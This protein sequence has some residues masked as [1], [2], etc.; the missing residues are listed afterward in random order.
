MNASKP[1]LVRGVPCKFAGRP[2]ARG[3]PA[4]SASWR[5]PV[6]R[7]GR[8]RP[9]RA[10]TRPQIF[11]L[12]GHVSEPTPEIETA[13]HILAVDNAREIGCRSLRSRLQSRRHSKCMKFFGPLSGVHLRERWIASQY[14]VF[15]G[16]R[17]APTIRVRPAGR[18]ASSRASSGEPGSSSR[19]WTPAPPVAVPRFSIT[20]D[21]RS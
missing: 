1:A 4:G 2:G 3:C 18:S 11:Q 15:S 8:H 9:G 17:C 6:G 12:P 5:S 16:G 20:K 19:C 21:E 13:L 7:G 10:D 14:V